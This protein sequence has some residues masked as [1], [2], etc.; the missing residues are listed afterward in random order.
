MQYVNAN[1]LIYTA[2]QVENAE[3]LLQE[4]TLQIGLSEVE[5]CTLKGKSCIILDFGKELSGGARILTFLVEGDKTVRLRFGESVGE[6]CAD[7]KDGEEGY[8]ATNDH[9][10][11]DFCVELQNYSDMTFGQTGYRFLR[12]DTL[13]DDT[14][15]ALKSIVA[16]V[17][18]DTRAELGTFECDDALVN[19]IWDT[20]AYT[21]RLCLQNGFIW[22]GVK[23]DRL[24]WI[25]DLYPEALAAHY[26]FGDIPE[27]L[28]CLDFSMRQAP[29][30]N[31][32]NRM[33]TYSLWWIL[34]K[35]PC[36]H[37]RYC[38][39]NYCALRFGRWNGL[40]YIQFH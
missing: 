4:K 25:G 21:L 24:V 2:G 35:I 32:I 19:D 18:T 17:D 3:T 34:C 38:G 22:D 1:K 29:L 33:P 14:V 11:R 26:L 16:A 40:L 8:G 10:L 9:S 39:A 37:A 20:A 15:L 6:T 30:P 27:T 23:R 36:V 13:A 12:I 7:L 5:V 28:N 31:S